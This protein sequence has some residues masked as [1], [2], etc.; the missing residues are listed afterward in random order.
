MPTFT[1]R[2]LS[3]YAPL[4]TKFVREVESLP[5]PNIGGMPEPFFPAFGSGYERSALRLV[6][7][8]QDTRGWGDLKDFIHD[9]KVDPQIRLKSRLDEFSGSPPRWGGPR[10]QFGGFA[11]MILAALHGQKDWGILRQG[12]MDELVSSFA[13][14]NANAVELYASTPSKMRPPVPREYWEAIRKAGARFDRFSHLVETIKPQAAIVLCRGM[15][16]AR[17]FEGYAYEVVSEDGR[18][19]HYRLLEI[20]VD[21]FHAPHPQSMSFIEGADHFCEKLKELFMRHGIIKRFPEFLSRQS[22]ADDNLHFLK[23]NAPPRG[24]GFDKYDFVDWVA[25]ELR[26]QGTFMSV[27]TLV[28]LVNGQGYLTNY[29][30]EF[31]GGR[32]SYKLVSGTYH[33][34]NSAGHADRARNVAL[35][36]RKPNFDY[37]YDTD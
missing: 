36:F 17:Y 12:G 25:V 6:I 22:E 30:T 32:G 13:W 33:R 28:S 3:H 15:N 20:G 10:N 16:P 24:P 35:A 7:I 8:G 9:G 5:H 34:F 14:G 37:A 1:Q 26:K 27:P 18:L 2:Y 31:S 19:K 4:V 23:R 21:V 11:M 29:G